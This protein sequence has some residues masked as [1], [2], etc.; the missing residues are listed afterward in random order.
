MKLLKDPKRAGFTKESTTPKVAC[1]VF[2]D[3]SA[4]LE[5]EKLHTHRARTKH[6]KMKLCQFR[7]YVTCVEVTILLIGTLD[8]ASND[9]TKV[10][11]KITIRRH[12][13]T[14]QGNSEDLMRRSVRYI[15]MY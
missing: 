2:K 8:Q 7:D 3:N 10:V 11:N 12:C 13:L 1:K 6:I 14:M 5:M 4:S 15:Y 9:L